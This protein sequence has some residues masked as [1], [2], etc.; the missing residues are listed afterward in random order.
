MAAVRPS[1]PTKLAEWWKEVYPTRR[2][3]QW[4]DLVSK[5]DVPSQVVSECSNCDELLMVIVGTL[6]RDFTRKDA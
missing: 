4:V 1:G 3:A 6:D 2:W 5:L